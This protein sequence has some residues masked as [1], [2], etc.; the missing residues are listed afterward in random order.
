MSHQARLKRL[1]RVQDAIADKYI[2]GAPDAILEVI[3]SGD[4]CPTW[5]Q[6]VNCD[7]GIGDET[8]KKTERIDRR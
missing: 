6:V 1:E 4:Y 8:N 5:K 2:V 7:Y 3:V